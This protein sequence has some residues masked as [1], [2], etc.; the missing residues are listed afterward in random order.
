MDKENM[1][2]KHV[3]MLFSHK[4]KEVLSLAATWVKL[5]NIVKRTRQAQKDRYLMILRA[6]GILKRCGES[7]GGYQGQGQVAGDGKV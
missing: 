3:A 2:H 4:M 7:S 6:C 5:E 1:V